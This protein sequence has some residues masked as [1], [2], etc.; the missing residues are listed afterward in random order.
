MTPERKILAQLISAVVIAVVLIPVAQA[1]AQQSTIWS[2]LGIPQGLRKI[3]GAMVNRRGNLPGL[4]KKPPL[5]AIADP[6]NL[7]SDVPAIKKAAQIKQAEDLKKQKIKA[8]KYLTSV[9]C[10]CYDVDG[11]VTAALLAASQDCTEDVRLATIEAISDAAEGGCCSR[12]GEVSCCKKD[13][14][15]RLAEI[16]YELDEHGCY[17]EPSE[18]VREAA[19]EALETCCP[20]SAPPVIIEDEPQQQQ[21]RREAVEGDELPTPTAPEALP[22]DQAKVEVPQ[23]WVK[24]NFSPGLTLTARRKTAA[25]RTAQIGGVVAHVSA[26][27]NLAHIQFDQNFSQASIGQWLDVYKYENGTPQLVGNVQVVQS[28]RGSA[29]VRGVTG[30]ALQVISQGDLVIEQSAPRVAQR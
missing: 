7:E 10:G 17:L 23:P 3:N 4:E 21:E 24:A 28:F 30:S 13:L 15:I 12:C 2:F 29:N 26:E 22:G 11:G 27:H 20:S 5:K 14:I 8:I 19:I 25:T 6:A 18:R 16:A 1:P 9:G